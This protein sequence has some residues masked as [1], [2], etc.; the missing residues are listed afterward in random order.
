MYLEAPLK[1]TLCQV[2][3][4][5]FCVEQFDILATVEHTSLMDTQSYELLQTAPPVMAQIVAQCTEVTPPYF[6]IDHLSKAGMIIVKLLLLSTSIHS[7]NEAR[8][9]SA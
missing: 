1:N 8:V 5:T 6:L 2:N 4:L 9:A 7:S 3:S